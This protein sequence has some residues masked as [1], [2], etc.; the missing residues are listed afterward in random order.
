M[1]KICGPISWVA[2]FYL[3]NNVEKPTV[4]RNVTKQVCLT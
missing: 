2:D 4:K 3:Y 1:R